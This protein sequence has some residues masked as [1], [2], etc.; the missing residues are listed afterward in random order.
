MK[1]NRALLK[2]NGM[3]DLRNGC[4]CLRQEY[5]KGSHE[6]NLRYQRL[7]IPA[8]HPSEAKELNLDVRL[9]ISMWDESVTDDLSEH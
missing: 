9:K 4:C 3:N 5:R 7:E 2:A 8:R 1:R 6:Q